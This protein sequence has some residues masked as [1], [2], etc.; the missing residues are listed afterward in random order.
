MEN[1]LVHPN[2]HAPKHICVDSFIIRGRCLD[3]DVEYK[4]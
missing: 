4:L 3:S 2:I 1:F